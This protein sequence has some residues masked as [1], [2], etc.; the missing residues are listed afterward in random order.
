[1]TRLGRTRHNIYRQPSSLL[2]GIDAPSPRSSSSVSQL[3]CSAL[4]TLAIFLTPRADV[5]LRSGEMTPRDNPP[6]RPLSALSQQSITSV[7]SSAVSLRPRPIATPRRQRPFSIAVTG[8]TGAQPN[9][10][11]LSSR[12]TQRHSISGEVRG[13]KVP[14]VDKDGAKPPLPR[15]HSAKKTSSGKP[16][17]PARRNLDK[18]LKS[19]K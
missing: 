4:I 3:F 18:V 10:D 8:V 14:L 7:N 19:A 17:A 15:V 5:G 12:S 16:E 9:E 13:P 11:Q 2:T 1:M 6:S